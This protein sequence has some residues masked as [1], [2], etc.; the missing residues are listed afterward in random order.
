MSS[1]LLD[2]FG[3]P[4]NGGLWKRAAT[5]AARPDVPVL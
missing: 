4:M 2:G 3:K 1:F 5:E